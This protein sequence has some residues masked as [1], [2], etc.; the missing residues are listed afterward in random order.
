MTKFIVLI[1]AFVALVVLGGQLLPN[2]PGTH[3]KGVKITIQ[4]KHVPDGVY[5]RRLGK[6]YIKATA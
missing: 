4:G 6:N 3:G 1:A 5:I 2:M